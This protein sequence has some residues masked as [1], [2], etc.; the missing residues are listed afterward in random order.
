MNR[1]VFTEQIPQTSTKQFNIGAVLLGLSVFL[2]LAVFQP[3]GTY[4]FQRPDKMLLLA[5]YGIVI[6][7]TA[8]V[9]MR[10]LRLFFAPWF[11]LKTWNLRKELIVLGI[12][13]FVAI[14]GTYFYHYFMIGSR[15]SFSSFLFFMSIAAS[16]AVFPILLIFIIRYMQVKNYLDRQYLVAELAPKPDVLSLEGE[17]KTE[18]L[19]LIRSELLFIKAADNYVEL[20]VNKNDRLDR[21]LLRGTLSGMATQLDEDFLQVHRSYIVNINQVTE[22]SGKS[23]NYQLVFNNQEETV[24]VS[25]NKIQEVRQRL[26]AKPV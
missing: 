23:P 22:I 25:R 26:A 9:M 8:L 1:S 2:I 19:T 13:T 5:G 11:E 6:T 21:H 4:T 14:I 7:L 24:P 18:K 10:V 12:I 3:F 20:Y 16:T 15:L 17:N